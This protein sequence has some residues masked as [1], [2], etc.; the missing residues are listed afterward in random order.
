MSDRV[1]ISSDCSPVCSGD[2]Y[3]GVPITCPC[4]VNIE[5]S[6]SRASV[7]FAMPKSITFG[8]GSPATSTTITLLGLMSR[9]MMPF[10]CACWTAW[11]TF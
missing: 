6:V 2:M 1:S 11:Q 9:W 10:W 4:S 7:A 5:C 3:A 8:A